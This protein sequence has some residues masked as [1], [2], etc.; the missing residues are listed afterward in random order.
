MARRLRLINYTPV[1]PE[2]TQAARHPAVPRSAAAFQPRASRETSCASSKKAAKSNCSSA[3][4]TVDEPPGKPLRRL[5]ERGLGTLNRTDPVFLGLQKT[6]LHDPLLGFLGS[7]DHPGDYRSSGCTA[8]HVV[9]ANDRSPTQFRLVEQIRPSR[10]QFHRGQDDSEKRARPSDQAS[11]HPL[12]SLEPVHELPHASGQSLR[13]SVSR[14]HLVGPGNRRRVH[15]SEGATESD[16]RRAGASRRKAIPKRRPRAGSGAI[17]DF[18]EQVAE[19]NPKLKHTQFADYHGHGWVFRAVFKHDR[20]GNL[21]DL[22]RQ[23]DLARR[24][25]QIRE[26]G[27]S[28]GRAS[29]A[30][31]AMRRLPFRNRRPRQRPALR[32]AAQRDDDQLHR[33]PRHRR[34]NVRR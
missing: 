12:D 16:R 8:C 4:P 7:N 13:E 25:G 28:E 24:S 18:L 34:R 19:L 30:R 26:G 27:S 10:S 1:T 29:R 31:H 14:L 2:D 11:V 6:R 21:L 5:S 3:F 32:R 9:Y 15:V 22:R 17:T 20:K 23:Q 33:L